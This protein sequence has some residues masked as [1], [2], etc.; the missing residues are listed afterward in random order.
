MRTLLFHFERCSKQRLMVG[1]VVAILMNWS[2]M[3]ELTKGE[4]LTLSLRT[5]TPRHTIL[6][7][8]PFVLDIVICNEGRTQTELLAIGPISGRLLQ[9]HIIDPH[10]TRRRYEAVELASGSAKAPISVPESECH[11]L[12]E[13]LF[14]SGDGLHAFAEPGEYT[15][16]ATYAPWGPGPAG[17]ADDSHPVFHAAPLKVTVVAPTAREAN[18]L[19]LWRDA[20][21]DAKKGKLQEIPANEDLE[22]LRIG[23]ADTP[24]GQY[25]RFFLANRRK[26]KRPDVKPEA[27]TN[28]EFGLY[29]VNESIRRYRMLL[30]DA[31]DFPLADECMLELARMLLD[32]SSESSQILR[33]LLGDFPESPTIPEAQA[34]LDQLESAE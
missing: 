32:N 3:S 27:W 16:Q 10:G 24:Y 13:V 6:L 31:P 21:N 22:S 26:I 28:Q 12:R 8:E 34:L 33:E 29:P 2:A 7:L 5:A 18:A 1:L 14:L 4:S 30:Q 15:V 20:T 17:E 25:A 23:Y 11:A 19:D 9:V